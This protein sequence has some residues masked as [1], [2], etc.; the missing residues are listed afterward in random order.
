MKFFSAVGIREQVDLSELSSLFVSVVRLAIQDPI[1]WYVFLQR[2]TYFNSYSAGATC[3]L[4]SS[5]ALSR[6]L[7]VQSME[8]VREEADRGNQLAGQLMSTV[9]RHELHQHTSR[10]TLVQAVLRSAGDYA[11]LL[12]IERNYL[13]RVPD[14]LHELVTEFIQN[15]QGMPGDVVSIVKAAGFHAASELLDSMERQQLA[16]TVDQLSSSAAFHRYL[17][18]HLP[19]TFLAQPQSWCGILG[20]CGWQVSAE[21]ADTVD[22]CAVRSHEAVGSSSA[23][24]RSL[25]Q[26]CPDALAI[27]DQLLDYRPETAPQIEHWVLDGVTTFVELQRVLLKETYRECLL[28]LH[29]ETQSDAVP[30]TELPTYRDAEWEDRGRWVS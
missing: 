29:G 25:P 13:S 12:P 15:Y 22:D 21:D 4:A 23:P 17:V 7:F 5:I 1:T 3:R 8:P 24:S 6:Y 14:W 11:G 9:L 20:R 10:R 18:A 2:Y 30:L 26:P 19:S 28:L 27:L 16:R